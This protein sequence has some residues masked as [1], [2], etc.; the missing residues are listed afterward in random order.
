MQALACGCP[1]L[2]SDIPSNQ[3]WVQPGE[4]GEL[5][6]DGDVASLKQKLLQMVEDPKL[7][8]YGVKAREVAEDR[9]DWGKNFQKL[10][11]AYQ[12]AVDS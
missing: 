1:A 3:E 11:G 12:L 7:A 8:Q 6:R 10:L 2:V 4:V 9:A 5:F